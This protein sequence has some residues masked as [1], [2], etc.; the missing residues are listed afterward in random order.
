MK[1]GLLL[2]LTIFAFPKIGFSSKY[3]IEFY[4]DGLDKISHKR[5]EISLVA[6][7]ND[8]SEDNTYQLDF[9]L[10]GSSRREINPKN[11]HKSII[12]YCKVIGENDIELAKTEVAKSLNEL[13]SKPQTTKIQFSLFDTKKFKSTIG[14][15]QFGNLLNEFVVDKSTAVLFDSSRFKKDFD[16]ELGTLI[17]IDEINKRSSEYGLKVSDL[18][19]TQ[20][21]LTNFSQ[22]EVIDV[23]FKSSNSALTNLTGIYGGLKVSIQNSKYLEYELKSWGYKKVQIPN[24][25]NRAYEEINK[26]NPNQFF[27]DVF[28]KIIKQPL[29]KRDKYK[30]YLVSSKYQLDSLSLKSKSYK[31]FGTEGDLDLKIYDL[32]KLS[33]ENKYVAKKGYETNFY[34][35]RFSIDYEIKD[36]TSSLFSAALNF[37]KAIELFKEKQTKT[38]EKIISLYNNLTKIGKIDAVNG[39]ESIT[40]DVEFIDPWNYKVVPA[41][42]DETIEG[43]NR[44][45]KR[46]NGILGRLTEY[47]AEYQSISNV[48]EPLN[49]KIKG[50]KFSKEKTEELAKTQRLSKE[51]IVKLNLYN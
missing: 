25:S 45:V 17:F 38:K 15:E 5:V 41:N 46:L 14:L 28:K 16:Y 18:N 29:E 13:Y 40:E 7:E 27:V 51:L 21:D 4:V 12:F 2:L 1:T 36:L 31:E 37:E 30:L 33:S 48:I 23:S 42:G 9:W 11:K 47:I 10:T 3:H 20:S 22:N 35:K 24:I 26:K 44:N 34:S 49:F 6:F 39:F 32:F 8:P 43:Y 19:T 50:V